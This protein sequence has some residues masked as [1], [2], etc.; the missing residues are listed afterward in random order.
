MTAK[1]Q[2][3]MQELKPCPCCRNTAKL[4]SKSPDYFS[5]KDWT[6][7]KHKIKCTVCP[8]TTGWIADKNKLIIGWNTR[9]DLCAPT[10]KEAQLLE[11]IRDLASCNDFYQHQVVLEKH[12]AI[13]EEANSIGGK[14]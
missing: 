11:V 14:K 13:I 12:A 5:D 3:Q 10:D 7:S 9:A 1:Q 4:S 6:K 2:E 8:I